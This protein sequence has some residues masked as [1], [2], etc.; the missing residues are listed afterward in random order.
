M[1]T[2]RFLTLTLISILTSCVSRL[3]ERGQLTAEI[4]G[5]YEYR[6]SV[7]GSVSVSLRHTPVIQASGT[8]VAKDLGAL[9]TAATAFTLIH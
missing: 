5:D 8:A 4:R 6:K 9:G 2:V 3:Y 7:D 1:K